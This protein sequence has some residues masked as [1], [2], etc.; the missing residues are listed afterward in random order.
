MLIWFITWFICSLF[1]LVFGLFAVY[2]V[3]YLVFLQVDPNLN[4]VKGG[5]GALLREKMVEVRKPLLSR[6]IAVPR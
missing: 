4:L 5:G 6:P 2:L 3:C 1:G